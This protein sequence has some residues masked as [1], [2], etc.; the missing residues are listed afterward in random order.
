MAA[1][2]FFADKRVLELGCG[3]GVP[4]LAAAVLGSKEVVLTDL[5]MAVSWIQVNI[6][7]NRAG[8]TGN[9][10]AEP[11][12]WGEEPESAALQQPFDVILCSDLVYGEPSISHKLV[13]TLHRLSHSTTLIVSAHEARFAGDRGASFFDRLRA[14]RFAVEPVPMDA[15][16]AVYRAEGI[17]VHLIHPPA[18]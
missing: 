12:M 14:E 5:P 3:I 17:H 10:S 11:L 15:L 7:E 4:G 1:Q 2:G 13:S 8:F 6:D 18:I 9:V 16:D